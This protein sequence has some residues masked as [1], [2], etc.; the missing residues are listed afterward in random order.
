M[1]GHNVS[2]KAVNRYTL[3]PVGSDGTA[4]IHLRLPQGSEV[5]ECRELATQYG[6]LWVLEPVQDPTKPPEPEQPAPRTYKLFRTGV[7][8]PDGNT[9][10]EYVG[11]AQ[12]AGGSEVVH[13]FEDLGASA[14][15][16]P[17]EP[18]PQ[19]GTGSGNDVDNPP[20]NTDP[21]AGPPPTPAPAEPPPTGLPPGLW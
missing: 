7:L 2:G 1:P 11:M 18:E 20:A 14:P 12:L 3:P 19:P 8:I 13:V 9:D 6:C 15:E 4:T 5:L 10:L 16:S 17:G 21:P